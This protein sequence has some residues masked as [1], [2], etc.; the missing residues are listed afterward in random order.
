MLTLAALV[1]CS[2][3]IGKTKSGAMGELWSKEEDIIQDDL[4]PGSKPTFMVQDDNWKVL[5]LGKSDQVL[6]VKDAKI[7]WED[8]DLT[9]EEVDEFL[10]SAAIVTERPNTK[11]QKVSKPKKAKKKAVKAKKKV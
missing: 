9:Q 4:E 2:Y 11:P 5:E 3:Q 8:N 1:Y 7:Y 10:N 6:K